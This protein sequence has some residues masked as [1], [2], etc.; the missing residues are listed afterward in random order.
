MAFSEVHRIVVTNSITQ[1]EVVAFS[2]VHRTV[3]TTQW[4][5]AV[6]LE[7]H[8]GEMAC[9]EVH[10]EVVAFS[11]AHRTVV[12]TRWE[13][14]VYSE[15]HREEVAYLEA[16]SVVK[17]YQCLLQKEGLLQE[18]WLLLLSK[19]KDLWPLEHHHSNRCN[20]CHRHLNKRHRL[21]NHYLVE[22]HNHSRTSKCL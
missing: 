19:P 1:W 12:A 20:K 4:E 5:V 17:S 14:A 21:S 10:K 15:A 13:E 9:L 16:H 3:V 22:C 6:Y 2:E 8:K 7:V 11:E 18:V